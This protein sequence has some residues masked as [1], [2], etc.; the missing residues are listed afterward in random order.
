V[1]WDK[2]MTSL[3]FD[4]KNPLKFEIEEDLEMVSNEEESAEM[5]ESL[6]MEEN[7]LGELDLG[8]LAKLINN[9]RIAGQNFNIIEQEETSD[10]EDFDKEYIVDKGTESSGSDDPRFLNFKEFQK[11]IPKISTT[12]MVF[13]TG[14][15]HSTQRLRILGDP[16]HYLVQKGYA[17][18][19]S[20]SS[21]RIKDR[22]AMLYKLKTMLSL[23]DYISDHEL[24]LSVTLLNEIVNSLDERE[25]W[26]VKDDFVFFRDVDSNYDVY[27]KFIG[28]LSNETINNVKFK[29]GHSFIRSDG[30]DKI[31]H[32]LIP[33]PVEKKRELLESLTDDI[34]VSRFMNMKPLELCYYRLFKEPFKRIG[35]A[36]QLL[37]EFI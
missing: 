18:K 20:I 28:E 21:L 31:K 7:E 33:I 3:G 4:P 9:E 22:V 35:F 27:V 1:D 10:D 14:K 37:A 11:M 17:D 2:T 25:E 34:D 23:C 15:S 13:T 30:K 12:D 5:S 16:T 26:P 8:T 6:N 19:S 36:S 24:L 29:G 32:T